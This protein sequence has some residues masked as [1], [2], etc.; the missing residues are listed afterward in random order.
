MRLFVKNDE[1]Y[2]ESIIFSEKISF[3]LQYFAIFHVIKIIN[4]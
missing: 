4:Y 2:H 3:S 1:K